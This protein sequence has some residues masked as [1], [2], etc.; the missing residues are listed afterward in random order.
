MEIKE[1]V[2]TDIFGNTYVTKDSPDNKC[3]KCAFYQEQLK[4]TQEMD[5][6]AYHSVFC[7][8]K[9]YKKVRKKKEAINA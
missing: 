4:Y 5:E 9:V 6:C 3:T 1:V 8:F 2:V 7:E